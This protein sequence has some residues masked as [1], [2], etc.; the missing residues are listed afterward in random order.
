MN[1]AHGTGTVTF[2]FSEAPV[3][4]ILAD[5]SAVGSAF[6]VQRNRESNS[7]NSKVL[8]CHR[9]GSSKNPWIQICVPSCAVKA[10]LAHGDYVG[11]CS[12]TQH[13]DGA[14]DES[15]AENYILVYPDPASDMTTVRFIGI[16]DSQYHLEVL[17][18]VGRQMMI[19]GGKVM[20]GTNSIELIL[21]IFQ[22]ACIS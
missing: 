4:F 7:E 1:V 16:L 17:D 3:A 22:K 12:D 2:A 13:R 10:H 20:E 11:P 14:L 8:V 15:I 19:K 21:T 9:T 18:L 6:S 5:T